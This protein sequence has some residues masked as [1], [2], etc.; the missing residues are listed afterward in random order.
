MARIYSNPTELVGNTPLLD[1][2]AAVPGARATVLAKLEFYNPASNVK[3]RTALSIVQTAIAEGKLPPGGT[4]V[5]ASSGN[6]GIALAWVGAAL[7]YTVIIAMPDDA[8]VERRSLLEALGAEVVLTPGKDAMAGANQRAGQIVE[9]TPG[10]FLAGQGGNPANPKIHRETTGPEI[11]RDTDGQLDFFVATT[12]TG[13][14]MTG[15]GE[16]LKSQ[17]PEVQVVA[18]EPAEAPVLR[19]GGEGFNPHLIQGIIGG[20]GIPPVLDLELADDVLDVPGAEAYRVAR[21][22]A[23]SMGLLV[24]I[25]SG[26]ALHA[27]GQL[28]VRPENEGKTIVTVFADSGERYLSTGLYSGKIPAAGEAV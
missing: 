27:A 16:Y 2:T 17:N 8:S 5:E 14:T 15:A 24:G 21:E 3:D 22:L 28:A 1:V 11:W 26:A 6:T 25:S 20:N 18:V 19:N 9:E 4:I 12:G 7:G 10:A 13:G 23:G